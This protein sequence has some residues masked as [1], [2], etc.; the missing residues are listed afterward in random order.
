[1]FSFTKSPVRPYPRH[2]S[3]VDDTPFNFPVEASQLTQPTYSLLKR[4][5]T[6]NFLECRIAERLL[7]LRTRADP[8]VA[9]DY[10]EYDNFRDWYALNSRYF[11]FLYES[12]DYYLSDII[13]SF[14]IA[15]NRKMFDEAYPEVL[16]KAEEIERCYEFL[17]K[18]VYIDSHDLGIILKNKW[19]YEWLSI[20]SIYAAIKRE[21][22]DISSY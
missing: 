5:D 7:T 13:V 21:H 17:H 14:I 10:Y 2:P 1:M 9:P 20:R 18:S 12:F 22:E 19:F 8:D 4:I 3:E 11:N 6:K 15:Q 16:G